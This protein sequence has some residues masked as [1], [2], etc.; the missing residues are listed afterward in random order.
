MQ[1]IP[2]M[3]DRANVEVF[4]YA[5]SPNDNTNFRQKIMQESEHFV[6]LSTIPCNGQAADKINKDGIHILIVKNN[7]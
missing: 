4:C 6:D 2:G 3:H 5:L 1:S 7:F